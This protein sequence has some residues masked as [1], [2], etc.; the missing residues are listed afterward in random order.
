M[1]MR[2][3]FRLSVAIGVSLLVLPFGIFSSIAQDTESEV[4]GN[5]K[6][7]DIIKNYEGRGTLSDG[8]DP[9]PPEEALKG[10][11][12]R[13]GFEIELVASEPVIG[14]PLHVSWDS[15]GR[16][17]VTQY[18]QYQ[19]PAGLKIIEYD[20][21]LRAQF[22]KV[23]E[24]PP[25]GTR[26]ADKITVFEDT[27]GDGRYDS[28]RDVITGLNI[29]TSCVTGAGGIWVSN[30]PY[31][32]FYP[33]ADGDANPDSEPQVKLSGFGIEDTHSVMNSLKWGAD[34]W[35]FG[36]N[37]STTTGKVENPATG[38][39]IE[40][41]GQMVWRFHPET[42]EFEIYAEGG[43]NTFSLEIDSMGRVFSGTNNGNTRGMYYPQGAYGKKG[44]GKHGPLTN[45]YAFGYINHMKHEGDDRRFAQAFCIYEGG[46]YPDEWE[47]KIIA[48]NSL[49]N[50][51]W[52][53]KL[54]PDGST[55]RTVDEE[56]LVETDDRWFR[57]V[58]SGVGPDGCVY[59]ADWYDTR[60]SHVRPVD[61]WHK[62]SGRI[63]RV[64]PKGSSPKVTQGDLSKAT[65]EE[66]IGKFEDPNWV[67]RKRAL[68]ELG[69]SGT[70]V[71]NTSLLSDGAKAT[72]RQEGEGI[73]E[74]DLSTPESLLALYFEFRDS[75][76][77][78]EALERARIRLLQHLEITT[79]EKENESFTARVKAVAREL[80]AVNFEQTTEEQSRAIRAEYATTA[81]RMPAELGVAFAFALM[82]FDEDFEDPHIPLLIWWAIEAHAEEAREEV[83]AV[84]GDPKTWE[85]RIFRE[86][87]AERLARRYA[88]AGGE[89]NLLSAARLLETAP[90][91][92]AKQRLMTGV[93]LAFQGKAMPALP[94]ALEKEMDAFA[95]NSGAG[96]LVLEI[97][98]GDKEALKKAIALVASSGSNPVERLELAKVLGEVGDP[99]VVP[100]LLRLLSLDQQSALKR[101]ALLSLANYDD[102]NIPKTILS[103]LGST[104]P[105]EHGVASTAHRV[106][107]GRVEWA[108]QFLDYVD[109]AVV[110]ARHVEPDVVQL[111]AQHDDPEILAAIRTYWPS[112]LAATSEE[113][114]E[115]IARIR[116]IVSSGEGDAAA[117]KVHFTARCSACHQ[118]FGEGQPIGPD[119]TPYERGNLDFW[120]P[121]IV[122][123][124]LEL[125]EGYLQYVATMK[126]GRVVIG[127]MNEQSPQTV[128]LRDLA[129]QETVL[130]RDDMETLEASPVSLMPPALLSGMSDGDL[131]DLF[132]YLRK[133]A[134]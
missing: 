87:V 124:S 8:S 91:D 23:P 71:L 109:R 32:L 53:S 62:N 112:S 74:E 58:F 50:I 63:Y 29:A 16:M 42:D 103:R 76:E 107:A 120:L 15:K 110:K 89:T 131:R 24:P 102:P 35:L 48:P 6:V 51:V 41:Q 104:L 56:P 20:N 59:I 67:V 132:T 33:D 116:G 75:E 72:F 21:H 101:V 52:V 123:P 1:R 100:T 12:V 54:L 118:L 77:E 88:M 43:G 31:L 5:D 37:G 13:D 81:K 98:R 69:W 18:L 111:L 66:L 126:D 92:D 85:S 45:P 26:G 9:T 86:F 105:R 97:Q 3:R 60:L 121:A 127:M 78:S 28:H 27:N 129:G 2:V 125:R 36:V 95:R 38:E 114:Q 113:N 47:G 7:A 55:F 108:K 65:A 117:G 11:R 119:L 79:P 134:K 70:S 106:V 82:D 30:P 122:A 80:V 115:E 46:L 133:G 96:G 40:W 68:L 73:S 39:M 34:G 17:W 10:F 19:F 44:W 49:H 99:S 83:L 57:P 25:H 130:S 61:D 22:D 64:K 128:K 84:A 94:E 14:Q 4:A 90:D 93:Q